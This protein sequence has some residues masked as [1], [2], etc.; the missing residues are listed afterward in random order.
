MA[1]AGLLAI[2]IAY[3]GVTYALGSPSSSS[4]SI[5]DPSSPCTVVT[6]VTTRGLHAH[7]HGHDHGDG[8]GHGDG[9]TQ[10]QEEEEALRL[11]GVCGGA[12]HASARLAESGVFG[13]T[14]ALDLVTSF[15]LSNH[16]F[17]RVPDELTRHLHKLSSLKTPN[18]GGNKL[19]QL[20]RL[21]HR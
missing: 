20:P 4:T 5:T 15:D 21:E 2:S 12:S 3:V 14:R 6:T 9:R 8:H 7:A 1:A 13:A 11:V 18:L 17:E 19:A 16:G 10:E